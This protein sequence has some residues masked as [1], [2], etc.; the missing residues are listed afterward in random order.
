MTCTIDDI[1]TDIRK[2][3][4]E[5]KPSGEE[6]GCGCNDRYS[7]PDIISAINTSIATDVIS[8]HGYDFVEEVTI[9]VPANSCR[10][11]LC[12]AG[13]DAFVSFGYTNTEPCVIANEVCIDEIGDN[14]TDT[15]PNPC[16]EFK[17]DSANDDTIYQYYFDP[18][19]PCILIVDREDTTLPVKATVNCMVY[20][21]PFEAGDE[22][23]EVLC[24]K[25]RNVIYHNAIFHL[26]DRDH[27]PTQ[28]Y[29]LY[30]TMH[31]DTGTARLRD[32]MNAD[33]NLHS[34]RYLGE[35]INSDKC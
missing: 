17:T 29:L 8:N 33:R 14:A 19:T 10:V 25:Y 34:N 20:P 26:I 7:D 22:L 16:F 24:K 1:L 32:I 12:N 35:D 27:R 28:E 21:D 13:C 23:P 6:N 11:N 2:S 18:K 5:C 4:N 3:L 9:D 30:S 15:H 31:R